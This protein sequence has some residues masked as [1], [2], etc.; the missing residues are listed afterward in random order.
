MPRVTAYTYEA[1]HH[2]EACALARFGD[3]LNNPETEGNE[4]NTIGACFST[5]E[6][7]YDVVC[8]DCGE[9]L[10]EGYNNGEDI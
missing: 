3:A 2:C 4:G 1:D 10:A 6:H 9:L 7:E 5:D 8:G